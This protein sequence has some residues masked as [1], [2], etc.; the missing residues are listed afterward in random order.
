[1]FDKIKKIFKKERNGSEMKKVLYITSNPK[2]EEKSFSLT[3]GRE[4]INLYKQNNPDDE[5][6][7]INLYDIDI[8]YIDEDVFSRWEKLQS[9]KG[10][11]ELSDT[12]KE[13]VG[14]INM[15]TDQF[16][17]ADKYIFVNPMW[18]L[19]IPPKM[20][21]YID[22]VV[23]ARKTFKYTENGP[24]GL[25]KDKK[26]VHIQASGGIYSEGPAKNLEFGNS[27]IKSVLGYIGIESVESILI[28]GTSMQQIPSDEIKN[29]A[30]QKVREV[31]KNF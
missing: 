18:N 14:K 24:V 6:I 16:I 30:V 8:P 17:E 4:F 10:F 27:Y 11:D 7:E 28:E 3:A 12:E 26:A 20:K 5:I 13:G 23:I 25:L 21:A 9:G 15:F 29:K 22:T 31:V 2:K 1:M 19:S